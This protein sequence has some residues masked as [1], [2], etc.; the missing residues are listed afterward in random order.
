MSAKIFSRFE[1][2]VWQPAVPILNLRT[3]FGRGV[4]VQEKCTGLPK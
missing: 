1:K 3:T 4:V 2:G